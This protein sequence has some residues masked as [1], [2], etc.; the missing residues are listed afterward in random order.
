MGFTICSQSNQILSDDVGED[1]V[2]S[3]P[4]KGLTLKYNCRN[5]HFRHLT[6]DFQ[7][8][9]NFFMLAIIIHNLYQFM[10]MYFSLR[11]I[12]FITLTHCRKYKWALEIS[13][14][15][16]NSVFQFPYSL[17]IQI[18]F[19]PGNFYRTN[20]CKTKNELRISIVRIQI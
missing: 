9:L 13:P 14:S 15:F 2:H 12:T 6:G 18:S 17:S 20:K 11:Y 3:K 4:S 19:L 5:T 8:L 10:I 16:F 7:N 1:S